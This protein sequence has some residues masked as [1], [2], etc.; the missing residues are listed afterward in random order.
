MEIFCGGLLAY[1]PAP[2]ILSRTLLGLALEANIWI[3]H[4]TLLTFPS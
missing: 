1:T 3:E 2:S 4:K